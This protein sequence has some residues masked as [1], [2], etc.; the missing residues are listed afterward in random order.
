[1]LE[2]NNYSDPHILKIIGHGTSGVDGIEKGNHLRWMFNHKLGFPEC[3]RLYRRK[4]FK[5]NHFILPF[6]KTEDEPFPNLELPYETRLITEIQGHK[7]K[8]QAI[9]E[10]SQKSLKYISGSFDSWVQPV[11]LIKED[12]YIDLSRE[13]SRIELGFLISEKSDFKIKVYSTKHIYFILRIKGTDPGWKD[14]YF[15]VE[16]VNRIELLGTGI[17]LA[18]LGV[19]LCRDI[20]D[21]NPW[22]EIKKDCDCGLPLTA[23]EKLKIDLI[24]E[25]FP[26]VEEKIIDCRL[27]KKVSSKNKNDKVSRDSLVKISSILSGIAHEGAAVPHGWT[28]FQSEEEVDSESGNID[29]SVS[30][31]DYLIA[32]TVHVPVAKIFDLYFVDQPPENDNS[33]YYDYKIEASWPNWNMRKLDH[34]IS[35]DHLETE[36]HFDTHYRINELIFYKTEQSKVIKNNSDFARTNQALDL[37]PT[38]NIIEFR[39]TQSGH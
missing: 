14:V 30:V 21:D 17:Q 38:D 22:Q 18:F 31:Y 8:I 11:M 35:F 39:F 37:Q 25:N 36:Q 26:D 24:E 20:H 34:Q 2:K 5:Q 6:P 3:M 19:W 12:L 9:F 33:E 10:S 28:L 7:E 29:A 13:V 15:D 32:Q 4:S 16:K 1:M 23:H 27:A